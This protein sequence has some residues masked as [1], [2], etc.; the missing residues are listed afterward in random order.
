M[1]N[2]NDFPEPWLKIKL[3]ISSRSP[4]QMLG[5]KSTRDVNQFGI[6]TKNHYESLYGSMLIIFEKETLSLVTIPEVIWTH[7]YI[8]KANF[9]FLQ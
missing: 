3:D 1:A 8:I 2:R 6:E 5:E 7:L 4:G 9:L